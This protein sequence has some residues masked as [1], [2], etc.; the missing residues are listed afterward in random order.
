MTDIEPHFDWPTPSSAA[1]EAVEV[2][3]LTCRGIAKCQ[4]VVKQFHHSVIH[5]ETVGQAVSQLNMGQCRR[6]RKRSS[7]L[8]TFDAAQTLSQKWRYWISVKT[9]R[10]CDVCLLI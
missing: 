7:K 4:N 5:T 6:S 10:Q 2:H 9:Y 1:F 8:K 3:R